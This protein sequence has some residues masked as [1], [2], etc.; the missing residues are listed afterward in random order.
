M[1]GLPCTVLS[2]LLLQTS[3]AFVLGTGKVGEVMLLLQSSSVVPW[4]L[5]PPSPLQPQ[6]LPSPPC[7]LCS[8]RAPSCL[9]DAG[10]TAPVLEMP[11]TLPDSSHVLNFCLFIR[12][13]TL[14]VFPASLSPG[15]VPSLI[16]PL[17]FCTYPSGA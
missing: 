8:S 15:S 11:F 13:L 9:C 6:C 16:F 3:R 14:N 10:H 4:A 17:Y 7:I 2:V 5:R 12:P 1:R